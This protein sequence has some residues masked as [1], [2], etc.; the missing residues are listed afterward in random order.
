[1]AIDIPSYRDRAVTRL[2]KNTFSA[3]LVLE[4]ELHTGLQVVHGSILGS[5]Y[6]FP[7]EIIMT[8]LTGII[9]KK[10]QFNTISLIKI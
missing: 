3:V 7:L 2:F 5:A 10:L 9:C 6:F 8:H 1:M 4:S